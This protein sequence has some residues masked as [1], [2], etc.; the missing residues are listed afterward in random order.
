MVAAQLEM[1]S[2]VLYSMYCTVQYSP[3][4]RS[5]SLGPLLPVC[6]GPTQTRLGLASPTAHPWAVDLAT[7]IMEETPHLPHSRTP[8]LAA[9]CRFHLL[10]SFF[11]DHHGYR[12]D[13][14]VGAAAPS[15]IYST[16]ISRGGPARSRRATRIAH[17]RAPTS[18]AAHANIYGTF[19]PSKSAPRLHA[20]PAS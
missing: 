7:H 4:H 11:N 12:H 13:A 2:T 16:D 1:H 10:C 5:P 18:R 20:P 17:L 19:G 15:R 6:N 8:H 14:N 9:H 3:A